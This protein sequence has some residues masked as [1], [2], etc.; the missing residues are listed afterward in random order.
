MRIVRISFVVI[1]IAQRFMRVWKNNSVHIQL[2]GLALLRYLLRYVLCMCTDGYADGGARRQ[3]SDQNKCSKPCLRF[4]PNVKHGKRFSLIWLSPFSEPKTLFQLFIRKY[5][6][7]PSDQGF[8]SSKQ[9]PVLCLEDIDH[10]PP[11]CVHVYEFNLMN[12]ICLFAFCAGEEWMGIWSFVL[13]TAE[14]LCTH[15]ISISCLWK[16]SPSENC[17]CAYVICS[18]PKNLHAENVRFGWCAWRRYRCAS[19]RVFIVTA[20]DAYFYEIIKPKS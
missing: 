17:H 10:R 4:P 18:A 1:C 2:S 12:I 14:N 15:E 9:N 13:M 5:S 7:V 16:L 11:P 20:K 8:W 6:K 3:H 19:D